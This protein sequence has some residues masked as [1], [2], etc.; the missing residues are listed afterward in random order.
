[1]NTEHTHWKTEM[2]RVRVVIILYLGTILFEFWPTI[3]QNTLSLL[4]SLTHEQLILHF[5][6]IVLQI[7]R[8]PGRIRLCVSFPP[9]L[10][11]YYIN[12]S[13]LS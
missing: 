4:I 5:V 12:V 8:V 9:G 11:Q 7:F 1:M 13:I 3:L 2:Q 6:V 10:R